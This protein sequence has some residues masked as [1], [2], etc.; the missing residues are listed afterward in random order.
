MSGTWLASY[1]ALWVLVVLLTVVVLGLVRQLGLIHLRLG[2]ES[3][4]L[5]TTEGLELGS[6]APDFRAADVVH[7]K[8]LTLSDLKG[9]P[10]V[11]VFIAPTCGPCRELM[12]HV[13]NFQRSRDG[14]ANVVLFNQ[15]DPQISLELARAYKLPMPVLPDPEGVISKSY[16]VRATPFGYGL[17]K[18]GVVRRRGVVNNLEGLEA[19]LKDASPSEPKVELPR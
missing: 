3:D 13:V 7:G 4:L 16:Q 18:N 12:P 6:M 11:L 19:L 8:E 9:R 1:V 5:A 17:D 15:S 14:K 2:P 10:N